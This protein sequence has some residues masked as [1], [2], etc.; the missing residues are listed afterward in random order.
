[1]G[2][3]FRHGGNRAFYAPAHDILQL[4]PAD[5]FRDAES[6]AATKAL[7][8]THWPSHPSRLNQGLGK[9]FAPQSIQ[10]NGSDLTPNPYNAAD[11]GKAIRHVSEADRKG[12]IRLTRAADL[13]NPAR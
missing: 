9:R 8:L 11:D 12:R 2:A 4:P 13:Q 10:P 1:M 7:E 6:Y 3:T 5:A